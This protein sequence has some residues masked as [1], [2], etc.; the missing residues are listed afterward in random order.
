M[1][2]ILKGVL[3]GPTIA[4]FEGG[5]EIQP[6]K[7]GSFDATVIDEGHRKARRNLSCSF[8]SGMV[9]S[10]GE[11][12]C[13][14]GGVNEA[15]EALVVWGLKRSFKVEAGKPQIA[16]SWNEGVGHGMGGSWIQPAA[17]CECDSEY[18]SK[19]T[20]S[21]SFDFGGTGVVTWVGRWL[22]TVGG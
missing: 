11:L 18:E 6:R 9:N 3:E 7:P 14:S 16:E 2:N 4:K 21:N 15:D 20:P 13:A 8:T 17:C 5:R 19:A 12:P 22:G 1:A 10:A